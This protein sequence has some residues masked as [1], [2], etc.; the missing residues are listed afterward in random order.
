[1]EICQ[2]LYIHNINKLRVMLATNAE[3]IVY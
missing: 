2:T 1:M 3:I